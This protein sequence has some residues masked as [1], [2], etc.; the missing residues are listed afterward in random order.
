MTTTGIISE[1]CAETKN[2]FVLQGDIVIGNF[3]ISDGEIVPSVS[4]LDGQFYRIV[5]SVFNDGIHHSS[6]TLTDEPEFHGAVWLMRV[7]QDVVDCAERILAWTADHAG[8]IS[9]PYTSESFGG[10]SYS[11]GANSDGTLGANWKNQAEFA[12]VLNKY[13]R[14][15]VL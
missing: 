11:R 9:S 7:P 8:D 1:I 10:Y 14:I 13:R 12:G 5:G 2:Y 4:L 15:R 6:D 3:E